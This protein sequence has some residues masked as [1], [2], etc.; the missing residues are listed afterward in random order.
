L[1]G[2]ASGVA[3]YNPVILNNAFITFAG[4]NPLVFTGAVS[5][6]GISANSTNNTLTVTNSAA[7]VFAGVI[8]NTAPNTAILT[9]TGSSPLTLSGT[10]TYG[11]LTYIN[12]GAILV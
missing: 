9:K 6:A 1:S 11:G 12:Q 3:V 4:S 7:T 2:L 5:P 10:N 8:N